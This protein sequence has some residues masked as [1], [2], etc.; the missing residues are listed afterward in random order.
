MVN[1]KVHCILAVVAGIIAILAGLTGNITMYEILITLATD[2]TPSRISQA[3]SL[4]LLV[5]S[6]IA[7]FAG[8]AV[9]LGGL[10]I[11]ANRFFIGRLFIGIGLGFEAWN[12]VFQIVIIA[13]GDIIAGVISFV[14]LLT[15]LTGIAFILALVTLVVPISKE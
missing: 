8:F 1:K 13:V 11:L 12:I 2:Y 6:T 5:I 10:V 4:F 15:T 7:S 9:I 14:V 3:L